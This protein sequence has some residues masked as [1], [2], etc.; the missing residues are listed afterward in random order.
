M[1][2]RL[3]I[4]AKVTFWYTTLMMILAILVLILTFTMSYGIIN[5]NSR[6][7]LAERVVSA[8]NEI[9]VEDGIID[10]DDDFDYFQRG[11]YLSIYDNEGNQQGGVLPEGFDRNTEYEYGKVRK[12]EGHNQTWYVYDYAVNGVDKD[13]LFI[14]RGVMPSNMISYEARTI[15]L[16]ILAVLPVLI[17]LA[18]IGGY[19]VT[20]RAFRPINQMRE[21]VEQIN[22][23]KDLSRRINLGE[24]KDEIYQLGKTFD[25]MFERLEL[26]FER[27]KQFTTDVSHELR[28]PISVIL[29]Q[30]E[31]VL[32]KGL[33]QEVQRSAKVILSQAQKMGKL[34]SQLLQLSRADKGWYKLVIEDVNISELLDIVIE[35]EQE[36]ANGKEIH[37]VTNISPDIHI[38]GDET[39]LMR[40]YVNLIS[41][42]IKYGKQG[43]KIDISLWS[44]NNTVI[45]CITDN[46]EGI[47]LENLDKIWERFYQVNPSRTASEDGNMG[48]GLSMVKWIV[49]AHN[50]EVTVDSEL[51]KW[52]SFTVT[53]P[54][55]IKKI[56]ST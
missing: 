19:L 1:K 10:I 20:K 15:S 30:S 3:S 9:E 21:T 35:E 49:Q 38:E 34:I 7:V 26:A 14:I 52:T 22:N 5:R 8:S 18:I 33:N 39:M 51:G 47:A 43:G 31:Y 53:L 6:D 54:I 41:N 50:G 40:M 24:G 45:S 56:R 27:E 55:C 29:S 46:G 17:L 28:T 36:I 37:I 12:I 42:A 44:E 11:I 16:V 23:G 32:E 4:T 2:N 13:P 25:Q 48:L